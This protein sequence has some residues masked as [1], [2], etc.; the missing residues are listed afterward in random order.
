MGLDITVTLW[1]AQW[2]LKSP[3]LWVFTQSF[4][5]TQIKEN[6]KA[7]RQRPVTRK[8]FPFDDV[9]MELEWLWADLGS[10]LAGAA[11]YSIECHD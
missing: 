2:R 10:N 11:L 6:I 3:A 1:W 9:I 4:I 5:Q 7:P 8:I